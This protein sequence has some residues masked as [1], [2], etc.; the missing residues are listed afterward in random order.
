MSF[1]KDE[2]LIVPLAYRGQRVDVVLAKLIPEFSRSQLSQWLQQGQITLNH[3]VLKPKDKVL[4]GELIAFSVDFQAL[5]TETQALAQ[6][7]PLCIV[8]EDET[9]LVINK[10]EG[11]VVHPGAGNQDNTLVNALLYHDARLSQLPR[12]GLVHRLDK[13]TTGLMVIAKTLS[14]Q[15]QLS[16]QIQDRSIDRRYIT[17]VQGHVISGGE[18]DTYFGRDP[19]NRLKMAVLSQ[20]RQAYTRFSVRKQF[21]TFTLLDVQL[22]TGRT[23]QIRVHMAH[24]KHPVVGDPLYGTRMRYPKGA[25]EALLTLLQQFKRQA[26]HAASLSFIHPETKEH[27]HFTAPLPTDFQELLTA[28]EEYLA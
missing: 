15:T 16:R 5:T 11:L 7:I 9:L 19:R 6:D 13:D 14:S 8:Y 26:L 10:P 12:A 28:M 22:M 17:L 24:I 2:P 25:D 20:G 23:H 4:G 21:Q 27:L 18:I 1:S 3:K